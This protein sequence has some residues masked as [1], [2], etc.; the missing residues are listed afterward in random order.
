MSKCKG[1]GAEIVWIQT[2]NGKSMPCNGKSNNSYGGRQNRYRAY[3]ALGD[4]CGGRKV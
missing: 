2:E 1:C 3:T 4:L